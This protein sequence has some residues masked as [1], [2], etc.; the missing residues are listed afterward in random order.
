MVVNARR[1]RHMSLRVAGATADELDRVASLR[2]VSRNELAERYLA[3][4]V[5][6]DEFPQ[7]CFRDGALGRRAALV[8]TRLDVWQVLETVRNHGNALTD[9]AE[10]LDLP[11]ERVRAAVR[12]AAAHED[13]IREIAERET[14]AATRAEEL[15]RA[16]QELLAG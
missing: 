5:R 13:E 2:G 11:V 1:K 16:E 15:W 12:Y 8:G 4:G 7:I 10:Y 3:E 14:A 9:A 6:Q